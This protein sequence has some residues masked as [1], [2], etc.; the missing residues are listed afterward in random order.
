MSF[1]REYRRVTFFLFALTFLTVS[2]KGICGMPAVGNEKADPHACCKKGW[3]ATVPSCCMDVGT[4]G[5][6]SNVTARVVAP[7]PEV[8]TDLPVGGRPASAL[9]TSDFVARTDSVHSPP[10]R[11]ILRV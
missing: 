8:A 4:D 3:Q 7:T 1:F 10:L 2:T 9:S 6:A 11:S 5:T